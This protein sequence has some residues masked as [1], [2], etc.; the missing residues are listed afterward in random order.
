LKSLTATLEAAQRASTGTPY[1]RARLAD[2]WGYA[3]GG[4]PE[5][6]YTGAEQVLQHAAAVSPGDGSLIRVRL[7][8]TGT[9]TLFV[10]RVA[11]PDAESTFSS[12]SALTTDIS[13]VAGVAVAVNDDDVWVFCVEADDVSIRAFKSSDNGAT[14]DGGSAVATAGAAVGALA[15]AFSDGN[16]GS[17]GHVLAVWVEDGS[18]VYRSRWG[19]SSWGART[20]STQAFHAV[21]GLAVVY[22]L[23]WQVAITGQ[24]PTTEDHRVWATRYG[25]DINQTANTWGSL[26][27]VAGAAAASGV[28]FGSPSAGYLDVWR[29]FFVETYAGDAAYGRQQW[30]TMDLSH[31]FN[32]EQWREPVA[33]DYDDPFGL[34]VAHGGGN[35]WLTAPDGVW[36]TALPAY[37]EL[38]VTD[39]VVEASVKTDADGTVVELELNNAGGAYTAYGSGNLGALQRGARLQLTPGYVSSAGAEVPLPYA[40][41][42][43]SI[44]LKTGPRPLLRLRA[45]DGWWLLSAWQARRQF[46]WAA[47][48]KTISQLLLFIV[49]RAGAEYSSTGASAALTTLQPAFT[50]HAGESG[51]TAVRRLL[52]MVE[53]VA[54]W[55]AAELTVLG[56]A[57]DDPPGYDLGAGHDVVEARYRDVGPAVNR[58]R[59]IG[60]GVSGEAFDFADGERAD[61]IATVVD[62]NLDD[63]DDATDR[64][65]AV[66]RKAYVLSLQDELRLF[67]VHCGVELWD[68]VDVTDAQAGLVAAPRRVRGYG[69]AFDSRRGRYEME[70][71]L[72]AV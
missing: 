4:R 26:R 54:L 25:D 39:D 18:D 32:E 48:D 47:G 38:D 57:V 29:L 67:G 64:A 51:Q 58:V 13:D 40:Y 5:R 11:A 15:A 2:F 44:E 63:A 43:E 12:W 69:W 49:A 50:I 70:L 14:F 28:S 34:A 31:D 30:T 65:A 21:N 53:D 1:V 59:V 42:V 8:T 16:G 19:G 36:L 71:T 9:D 23:D 46:V 52:A 22:L 56:H 68:V 35:Q 72:G 37:A 6:V 20:A 61:R 33:F 45:R 7:Q 55:D 3:R 41:W 62:A 60:W 66:L 24:E 27:E 10:S 17:D